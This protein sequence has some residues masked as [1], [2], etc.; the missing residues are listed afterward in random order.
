[1]NVVRLSAL[2]TGRLYNQEIFLIL[3]SVT[4]WVNPRAILLPEGLCQWKIPVAPSGIEPATFGLVTQYLNQLRYRVPPHTPVFS[5]ILGT[6]KIFI[7]LEVLNL[8]SGNCW[9]IEISVG[10]VWICLTPK[11]KIK[12][13]FH[14]SL[15]MSFSAPVTANSNCWHIFITGRVTSV[16]LGVKMLP[17]YV[18][19]QTWINFDVILPSHVIINGIIMN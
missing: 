13:I 4:G 6:H 19:V 8:M 1:M 10:I 18:L 14:S 11:H 2:R 12:S 7:F 15:I 5:E 16:F 9:R 17:F 3:I